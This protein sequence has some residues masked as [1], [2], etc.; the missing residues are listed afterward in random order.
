[1]RSCGNQHIP[2]PINIIHDVGQFQ[3][4]CKTV[5]SKTVVFDFQEYKFGDL[6]SNCKFI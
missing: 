5:F 4:R 6:I 3:S 1:M 2:R